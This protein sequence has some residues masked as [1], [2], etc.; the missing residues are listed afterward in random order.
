V[1]AEDTGT[2][3]RA[4]AGLCGSCRHAR[5]ITSDRGSAF[6]LCRLSREDP[7]FARYPRLPVWRCPGHERERP[8]DAEGREG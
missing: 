7:R 2:A 8:G 6:L 5:V 1:N 3:L 4:R